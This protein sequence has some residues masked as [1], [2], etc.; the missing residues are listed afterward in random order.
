MRALPDL[1]WPDIVRFHARTVATQQLRGGNTNNF[2]ADDLNAFVGVD[3]AQF[4][5]HPL[6]AVAAYGHGRPTSLLS[7]LVSPTASAAESSREF[8]D[9]AAAALAAE[10]SRATDDHPAADALAARESTAPAAGEAVPDG[11]P[12]MPTTNAGFHCDARD[13]HLRTALHWAS[14]TGQ[15]DWISALIRAGADPDAIDVDRRP[16]LQYAVETAQ[17]SA[18]RSLLAGGADKNFRLGGNTGGGAGYGGGGGTP[19]ILAAREGNAEIASLLC[20]A[21]AAL[22][23]RDGINFTALMTAVAHRHLGVTEV[24]LAFGADADTENSPKMTP[25]MGS[26]AT[27]DVPLT[28]ALLRSGAPP[29]QGGNGELTPL[30][31]AAGKG[32]VDLVEDLLRAGADPSARIAYPPPRSTPLHSAC[33]STRLGAVKALLLAGADE[34]MGDMTPPPAQLPAVPNA[35]PPPSTTPVG[36]V[37]LGNCGRDEDPTL[38]LTTESAAEHARR[39]DPQTM[40]AI[41]MAL[42]NAPADRAWRRRSW[43]VMLRV[44][45]EAEAAAKATRKKWELSSMA[46]SVV[47]LIGNR[48]VLGEAGREQGAKDAVDKEERVTGGGG[49]GVEN[50]AGNGT[51]ED[52]AAA[53]DADHSKRAKRGGG[54]GDGDKAAGGGKREGDEAPSGVAAEEACAREGSA[55]EAPPAAHREGAHL[56]ADGGNNG[57]HGGVTA[58][59][60]REQGEAQGEAGEGAGGDDVGD[61]DGARVL[62]WLCGRLFDLAA[63][64]EGAFRNVVLFL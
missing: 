46:G 40:E 3:N 56:D 38:R 42:R 14:T 49:G 51:A 45:A 21:G 59:V 27:S 31:L 9:R 4:V 28:R 15:A 39:R 24:L 63:V 52:A 12:T 35:P 41:R 13:E 2:L 20:D 62:R 6:H 22:E 25:L 7:A 53:A 47:D 5:F 30:H 54:G 16:P 44:S 32:S 8:A 29:G 60:A 33:R 10:S 57:S 17:V 36:V 48:L 37:G 61:G 26:V 34:T 55:K 23:E 58:V 19:L 18:V 50:G 64:E 43:L 1:N 11:T